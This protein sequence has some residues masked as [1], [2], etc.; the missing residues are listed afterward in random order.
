MSRPEIGQPLGDIIVLK[1]TE[2]VD[3]SIRPT[4]VITALAGL[5][6]ARALVTPLQGSMNLVAKNIALAVR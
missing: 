3:I 4:L 6:A 1:Q 5:I 2:P